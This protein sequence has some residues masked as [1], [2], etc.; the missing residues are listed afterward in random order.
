MG[1][2]MQ[3]LMGGIDVF[4]GNQKIGKVDDIYK[5]HNIDFADVKYVQTPLTPIKPVPNSVPMYLKLSPTRRPRLRMIRRAYK[6][7]GTDVFGR[8]WQNATRQPG[9]TVEVEAYMSTGKSSQPMKIRGITLPEGG[10]EI[11]N[12]ELAVE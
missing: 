6:I 8:I 11:K 4:I 10:M 9:T 7:M 1:D 5:P 2:D 12:L 3:D